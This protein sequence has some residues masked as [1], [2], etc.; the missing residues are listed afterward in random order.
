M[1]IIDTIRTIY[2]E[3][4]TVEVLHPAF[5]SEV[6]S[7]IFEA[8]NIVPDEETAK[9]FRRLDMNYRLMN[10]RL[11]CFIRS[12]FL[13]PP[14]KEPKRPYQTIDEDINLRFLVTATP[15]FL[16]A[17]YATAAGSK[18]VYHFTNAISHINGGKNY[19]NRS[20]AIYDAGKSY[21][22]GSIVNHSGQHY[23]SLRPVAASDSISINNTV[24]WKT[25]TA[26]EPVV[27]NA[28][29]AETATVAPA[30]SC[31]AVIDI[32]STGT[33]NA[34][35]ELFGVE[36]ELLKPVYTIAFKSKV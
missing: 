28:D 12:D 29:L 30:S 34:A 14:A 9:L 7:S 11:V 16:N 22:D 21:F 36:N 24:Y 26:D 10:D 33:T 19:I 27:N 3:L 5:E 8:I 1:K 6:G 25:I 20:S 13:S 32:R 35:Y 2:S 18:V 17:T 31:I 23:V 4:F 15:G